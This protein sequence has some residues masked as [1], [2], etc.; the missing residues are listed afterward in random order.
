M[1]AKS[2]GYGLIRYTAAPMMQVRVA[3]CLLVLCSA[4]V[5]FALPPNLR[6]GLRPPEYAAC[7]EDA[8]RRF[9]ANLPA[10][11]DRDPI[12]IR[13]ADIEECLSKYEGRT[14]SLELRDE[15]SGEVAHTLAVTLSG[16]VVDPIRGT[17]S[18]WILVETDAGLRGW[19]HKN[20]VWEPFE[21]DGPGPRRRITSP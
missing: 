6:F 3:V 19:I 9:H 21:V 12:E 18:G 5:V 2:A 11:G 13:D 8:L 16:I 10:I 4:S 17:E 14:F 15:P 20:W 1:S 7:H